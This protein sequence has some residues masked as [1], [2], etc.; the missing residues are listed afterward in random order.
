[1]KKIILVLVSF[2][3]FNTAFALDIPKLQ[4]RVND[5]ANILNA[6]EERQIEQFLYQNEQKNSSQVVLLTLKSLEGENLEDYS[7]RV[8]DK[9]KIGQKEYDNGALL[10]VAIAERKI[11]IEVGYGLE[12]I[13]TDLKAGY[14]IRNAI[15]PEFKKGNYSGGIAKGLANITGI[16]NKKF[17][18]SDEE[19]AR[20][21]NSQKKANTGNLP[22]S[23]IVIVFIIIMNLLG[24]IFGSGR[25]RKG[26]GF[27]PFLL[28]GSA[29]GGS[30]GGGFSSGGGFGG[31]SGGGGGFGGGGASGG[32]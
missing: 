13:I 6:N 4:G 24:R 5:H 10:L 21:Q 9:W 17:D 27:L 30:R 23:F 1:M 19:L 20:Y 28:L 8:V 25:R 18:I 29:L 16:I 26:M 31:F 22:F 12:S 3:F 2:I 15:T 11:R 14:I 32:W 7:M